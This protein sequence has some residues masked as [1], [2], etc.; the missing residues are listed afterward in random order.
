[1]E[2]RRWV[3]AVRLGCG[4]DDVEGKTRGEKTEVRNFVS[5]GQNS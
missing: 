1:M 3:R 5:H 2:V 4:T